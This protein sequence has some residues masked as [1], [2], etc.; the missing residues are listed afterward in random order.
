MTKMKTQ[1]VAILAFCS[2]VLVCV[3]AFCKR[4]WDWKRKSAAERAVDADIV[5]YAGVVESPCL[6]PKPVVP[7][8]KEEKGPQLENTTMSYTT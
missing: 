5:I 1:L 3:D 8:D 7:T 6:K 4:E 2:A